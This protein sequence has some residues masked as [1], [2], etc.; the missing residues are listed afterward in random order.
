MSEGSASSHTASCRQQGSSWPTIPLTFVHSWEMALFVDQKGYKPLG[1]R[2][3]CSGVALDEMSYRQKVVLL[4]L[5]EVA[6]LIN[7]QYKE[8]PV[9]FSNCL[10]ISTEVSGPE[11]YPSVLSSPTGHKSIQKTAWFVAAGKQTRK[12]EKLES[13]NTE[14]RRPFVNQINENTTEKGMGRLRW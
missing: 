4:T 3:L 6:L 13:K 8:H 10:W 11:N 5:R 2:Q 14:E 7:F 12:F 1:S 9:D